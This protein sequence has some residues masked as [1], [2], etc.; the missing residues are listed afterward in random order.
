MSA[1]L[2][3]DQGTTRVIDVSDIVDKNGLDLPIDPGWTVRAVARRE[4]LDPDIRAEWHS[5]PAGTQGR[6]EIVTVAGKKHIYLHITP[7]MSRAW[8]WERAELHV[9]VK[10]PVIPFRE[11]DLAERILINDFTTVH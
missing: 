4:A 3:I 1:P 10:E 11:E 8:T 2:S 9:H 7:A 6:A 5:S